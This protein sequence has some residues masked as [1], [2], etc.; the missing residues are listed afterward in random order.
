MY[1]RTLDEIPRE[2]KTLVELLIEKGIIVSNEGRLE[3]PLTMDMLY[4]IKIL[5]RRN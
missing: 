1:F 4:I 2:Y 3:Y 5:Q